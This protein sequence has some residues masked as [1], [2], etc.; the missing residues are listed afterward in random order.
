MSLCKHNIIPNSS[1]SWWGAWLNNNP[2]K[3]VIAP[4]KWFNDCTNMDYSNIVPET[5][6]KIKNY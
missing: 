3:I 5:W 2:N 6:I 1:F 4:E